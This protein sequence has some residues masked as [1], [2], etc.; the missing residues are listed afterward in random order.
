MCS[1][2]HRWSGCW[3]SLQIIWG[4]GSSYSRWPEY[5]LFCLTFVFQQWNSATGNAWYI[6]LMSVV[7]QRLDGSIKGEMRKQALDHFNAEGS[8]VLAYILFWFAQWCYCFVFQTGHER[9][10]NVLI[11][12]FCPHP[13]TSVSCCPHEQVAW[14]LTW[15]LQI[16]WSSLTQT[17]T[18][19]MT[20]RHRPEL[21]GSGRRD[22]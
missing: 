1:F 14:A 4:V 2:S 22:R 8:E 9:V 11:Y 21:T 10:W 3:T 5:F 12:L 19:K 18:P 7:L 20:C 13:R 15:L 16:R 6:R 17:G